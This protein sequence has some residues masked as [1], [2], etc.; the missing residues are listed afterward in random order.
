MHPYHEAGILDEAGRA[1]KFAKMANDDCLV[2]VCNKDELP[3]S[4][5]IQIASCVIRLYCVEDAKCFVQL[6]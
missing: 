4:Y 2:F 1:S 6:V 5:Q 3:D